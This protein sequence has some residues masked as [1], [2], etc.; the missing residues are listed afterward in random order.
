MQPMTYSPVELSYLLAGRTSSSAHAARETLA[1]QTL[2]EGD[3]GVLQGAQSLVAQGRAEVTGDTIV[4]GEEAR[5]VGFLL[6]TASRWIRVSL[7]M[8]N[9]EEGVTTVAMAFADRDDSSPSL[10]V[11]VLPLGNVEVAILA[12]AASIEEATESLVKGYLDAYVIVTAAVE[13]RRGASSGEI[14]ATRRSDDDLAIVYRKN[15]PDHEDRVHP[16][17]DAAT[18][19]EFLDQVRSL[20]AS[21]DA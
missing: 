17:R 20:I 6:G 8:E 15:V 13:Q 12:P 5:L 14:G 1:L 18:T 21:K 10:A 11:R 2:A 3:V 19:T 7:Q 9:E 4:I 16:Q